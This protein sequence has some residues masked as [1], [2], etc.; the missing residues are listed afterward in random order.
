MVL[1]DSCFTAKDTESKVPNES[2]GPFCGG[3]SR[4]SIPESLS[5]N[6]ARWDHI[7]KLHS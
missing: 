7:A 1:T 4:N 5:Q 6:Y 2:R 3:T